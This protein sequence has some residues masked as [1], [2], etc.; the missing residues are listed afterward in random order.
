[1]IELFLIVE[2]IVLHCIVGIVVA[3][4]IAFTATFAFLLALMVCDLI[5][6]KFIKRK[7]CH[8]KGEQCAS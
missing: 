4:G 7:F 6:E 1:M 5:R 2:Q 8:C 3:V